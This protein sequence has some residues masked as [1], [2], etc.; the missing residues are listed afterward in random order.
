M[1][2]VEV[3]PDLETLTYH[4]ITEKE[5]YHQ[6][7]LA[8]IICRGVGKSKIKFWPAGTAGTTL[9]LVGNC[10]RWTPIHTLDFLVRLACTIHSSASPAKISSQS[11]TQHLLRNRVACHHGFS[12]HILS[13]VSQSIALVICREGHHRC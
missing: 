8:P 3:E 1:L 6:N 9:P 11:Y 10:S 2:L 13:N 7:Q 4:I 12:R 5:H